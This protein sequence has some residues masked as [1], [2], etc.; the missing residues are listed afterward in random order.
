VVYETMGFRFYILTE[1]HPI[2]GRRRVIGF[3]S[4][5]KK[6]WDEYNLA[7]ILV[8]PPYHRRGL[9]KMLIAFSYELARREMKMGSP[10]KRLLLEFP[11]CVQQV[12]TN[13]WYSVVGPRP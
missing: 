1:P 2:T 6:S 9:G 13:N 3:F 11:P 12:Q 4:K 7:C 10:E 5:E 8:L